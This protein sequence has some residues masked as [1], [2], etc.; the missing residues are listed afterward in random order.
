MNGAHRSHRIN[1]AT[2]SYRE[3]IKRVTDTRQIRVIPKEE[4]AEFWV[5]F[6]KKV[7]TFLNVLKRKGYLD[8]AIALED[9]RILFRRLK[10]ILLDPAIGPIIKEFKQYS[11]NNPRS[12]VNPYHEKIINFISTHIDWDHINFNRFTRKQAEEI[13]S[14]LNPALVP[15]DPS[16]FLE[17]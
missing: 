7:E 10:S 16:N 14:Q 4:L 17:D 6:I 8:D 5:N 9:T 12:G 3:K 11:T 2:H 1:V 13:L 15:F